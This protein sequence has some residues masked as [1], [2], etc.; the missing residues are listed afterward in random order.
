M[1][2]GRVYEN[3]VELMEI[4]LLTRLNH[5]LLNAR[6]I[7]RAAFKNKYINVTSG[8]T[9]SPIRMPNFSTASSFETAP[10]STYMVL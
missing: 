10:T 3:I 7:C 9:G 1:D 4:F 6:I 5:I 2:Y 8:T